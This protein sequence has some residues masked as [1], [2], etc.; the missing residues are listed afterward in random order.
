MGKSSLTKSHALPSQQFLSDVL[1]KY[2][3]EELESFEPRM[4]YMSSGATVV[5]DKGARSL[6]IYGRGVGNQG[7]ILYTHELL[8]FL[9]EAEFPAVRLL[10]ATDG[11]TLV[12]HRRSNVALFE[13]VEGH[14]YEPGDRKQLVSAAK[15][16]GEYHRLVSSFAP[17]AQCGWEPMPRVVIDALEADLRKTTSTV[18]KAPDGPVFPRDLEQIHAQLEAIHAELEQEPEVSA[19]DSLLAIHGDFRAQN[20]RFEDGKVAAVL[21]FD[22]ARPAERIFDLC[23]ALVFFQAVIQPRALSPQEMTDFLKAY[24]KIAPL[25]DHEK[26]LL[27]THLRLALIRGLVL[28]LRIHYLDEMP[29][30]APKWINNYL[31]LLQWIEKY[32]EDLLK[33]A[34]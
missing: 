7:R 1:K 12:R 34:G 24:A 13:F 25:D 6:K 16:L 18:D 30:G 5:T 2:Y 8:R 4:G 15:A 29:S 19:G 20:L 14:A 21:D 9:A 23:Y 10:P 27:S 28:W 31:D 32:A 17:H 3:D 11:K 26:E 33:V 22:R